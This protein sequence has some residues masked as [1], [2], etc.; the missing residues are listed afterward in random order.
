MTKLHSPVFW[1]GGKNK[2]AKNI[3]PLLPKHKIYVEPFGGGANVLLQKDPSPVEVYNDVHQGLYA[4][5]YV[6]RNKELSLELQRLLTLT[7][8]SRNEFENCRDWQAETEILQKAYK[9]FVL[10]RQSFGGTNHSW[11]RII[12]TSARE[13]SATNSRWII[14]IESLPE[15]HERWKRVQVENL[16][17]RKCIL[18][19]D[20]PE[21]LFYLDPPYVTETR[22]KDKYKHDLTTQ[23]HAELIDL[24]L[25]LKGQAVISGYN[26]PLYQKLE[27]NGYQR[28]DFEAC[29]YASG[30]GKTKQTKDRDKEQVHEN[31]KRIESIWVKP[32]RKEV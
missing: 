21:T 29:C 12:S 24:I 3:I 4:L 18:D 28:H 10:N 11:G 30:E 2:M 16:D 6:L 13:M 15:L 32:E 23:D 9:F 17:Y 7:M 22:S 26:N 8:Y 5:F 1:Y 27:D 20:T 25:S 19:Y 14:A 31:K